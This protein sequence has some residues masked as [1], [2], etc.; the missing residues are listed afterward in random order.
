MAEGLKVSEHAVFE[1]NHYSNEALYDDDVS[2]WP[3]KY[4]GYPSQR[5]VI[6]ASGRYV[7][8]CIAWSGEF[9]AGYWPKLSIKDYWDSQFRLN[10]VSELR[11]G[12]FKN[13]KCKSCTSFM[14]Y[15]RPERE[16]VQDIAL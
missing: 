2:K 6:E 12:I 10:L 9:D 5:V 13:D 8:C 7:P 11:R 14:A 15:D 1:R 4:C 3:R 16:M